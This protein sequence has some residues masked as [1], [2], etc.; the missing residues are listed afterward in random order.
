M[1]QEHEPILSSN[2]HGVYGL[3]SLKINVTIME[4]LL[5]LSG[6]DVRIEITGLRCQFPILVECKGIRQIL[7][8]TLLSAT[9]SLRVSGA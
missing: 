7:H 8:S 1:K 5:W 2:A 9:Q 3:K 4:A 6:Q